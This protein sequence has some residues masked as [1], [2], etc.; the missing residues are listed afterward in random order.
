V[1]IE[2]A[3]DQLH[4]QLTVQL[5]AAVEVPVQQLVARDHNQRADLLARQ[6]EDARN[7][8][9]ARVEARRGPAAPPQ[10]PGRQLLEGLAQLLLEHHDQNDQ[11]HGG[12]A[13]EDAGRELEV[14]QP[15]PE[16]ERSHQA[17]PERHEGPARTPHPRDQ[18]VDQSRH[19]QD[20]ERIRPAQLRSHR[21]RLPSQH[22]GG[23]EE[24]D[25]P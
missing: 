24:R 15:G 12:Q 2:E 11:R 20:V 14:E 21:R 22:R 19:D 18:S 23:A 13:L 16:V 17:E 25:L 6:I 1:R 9:L 7:Q 3:L 10:H 5:H 8:D 4:A